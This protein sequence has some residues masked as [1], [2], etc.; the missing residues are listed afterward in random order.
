MMAGTTEIKANKITPMMPLIP[1]PTGIVTENK[2]PSE[3][4]RTL[5]H[6]TG[7]RAIPQFGQRV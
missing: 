2:T 5:C 7:T 1:I 4:N 3:A 6:K